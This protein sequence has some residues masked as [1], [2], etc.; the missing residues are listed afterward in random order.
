MENL[1]NNL[2][3][4]LEESDQIEFNTQTD[5]VEVLDDVNTEEPADDAAAAS[6]EEGSTEDTIDLSEFLNNDDNNTDNS[7]DIDTDDEPSSTG[8]SSSPYNT[9]ALALS[10]EGLISLNENEEIKSFADLKGII[11]RTIRENEFADLTE[12][13]R[14]YL[15]SIRNGIP[16]ETVV[17]SLKNIESFNKINVATLEEDE[18]LRLTLITQDYLSR[19]FEKTKAEKLAK[20]SVEL[21]EDLEDSKEALNNLKSYETEKI[22]TLN[23]NKAKEEK[24]LEKQYQEN[25]SRIKDTIQKTEAIIPGVPM[26][27]RV[28]D[29]VFANM[30][31]VAAYDDAGNPLNALGAA[32]QKDRE[33]IELKLNY[34]FTVTKGF[35]DFSTLKTSTKS[36]VVKDLEDALQSTQ[37]GSGKTR[38]SATHS[39]TLKGTLKAIDTLTL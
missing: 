22:K 37:L 5:E 23:E 29:E 28:K 8:S 12:N 19:G 27:S 16:E 32:L 15:E 36:S 38:S 34:L 33:G 30:T 20:R 31:K 7:T 25:L 4:N 26:N 18:D 13:Q 11:A 39:T 35:S 6:E 2:D 3:F 24:A 17:S 14:T 1:F 10:E 21:G 9:F